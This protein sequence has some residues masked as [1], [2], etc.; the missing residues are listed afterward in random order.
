MILTTIF[1]YLIINLAY[2]WYHRFLHNP[3]SGIL[4]KLHYI[5]HHKT[6]FPLRQL[7]KKTYSDDGSNGWFQTGGELVF[8]IPIFILLSVI[9]IMTSLVY[10][11]NFMLVMLLVIFIGESCHS[12]FHLT[13]DA[14]SH[15]ESLIIHNWIIKQSWYPKYMTLHDIH[16]GKTQY[17]FGFIDMTMDMLFGT[18]CDIKPK[19]MNKFN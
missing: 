2:Y 15:P 12:S 1:N 11:I 8:A 7:R 4:Y 3:K 16:H 13:K 14:I 9:F 6:D 5:G 17:N 18:Y 10:F 19:Y